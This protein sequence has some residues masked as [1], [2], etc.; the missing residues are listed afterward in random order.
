MGFIVPCASLAPGLICKFPGH[1]R[2]FIDVAPNESLDVVLECC[3]NGGVCVEEIMVG[4]VGDLF[5][6]NIHSTIVR[7]VLA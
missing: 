3:L 1:D 5:H 6:V 2:R 7:P 4:R